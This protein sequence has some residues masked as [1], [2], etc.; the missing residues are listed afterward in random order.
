MTGAVI[1]KELSAIFHLDENLSA[2]FL[3]FLF[4]AVAFF[5]VRNIGNRISKIDE[6]RAKVIRIKRKSKP[7]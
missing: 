4:F 7:A 2:A 6:Y 3:A 5:I 1:G